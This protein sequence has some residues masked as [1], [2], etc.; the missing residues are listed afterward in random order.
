MPAAVSHVRG[1][2]QAPSD[3]DLEVALVQAKRS[4]EALEKEGREEDGRK[5]VE[6]AAATVN[7]R[8]TQLQ[9]EGQLARAE[10]L[11]AAARNV[12]EEKLGPNHPE[13][14]RSL[15]NL[16][17]AYRDAVNTYSSSYGKV[18]GAPYRVDGS[19]Y[20]VHPEPPAPTDNAPQPGALASF[21][22]KSEDAE[23]DEKAKEAAQSLYMR[24]DRQSPR[25]WKAQVVPVLTLALKKASTSQEREELARTLGHL[26]PVARESVPVLT[27]CLQK[28]REPRERQAILVALGDM[29]PAAEPAAPVLVDALRYEN[30]ETRRCAGEA[31]VRMGPAARHAVPA[32]NQRAEAKDAVAQEVLRR[33]QG[34]E[35]R[36]GVADKCDCFSLQALRLAHR[37]IHTLA[38][39]TGVEVLVE[40]VPTLTADKMADERARDLGV[41]GVYLLVAHDT[42]AVQ[43]SVSEP[44]RKQGLTADRVRAAVEPRLRQK[45]F[46]SAL[47]EGVQVVARFEETLR[48]KKAP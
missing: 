45:D 7:R 15:Q 36:I 12:C 33:I 21:Q 31:I 8:A 13:T 43:V 16:A 10:P 27:E 24:L 47:R 20:G 41:Q 17:F 48:D 28:A 46:D 42:P 25:E 11:L 2:S 5:L 30:P 32:L 29:G 38:A 19:I 22:N 4:A 34:H 9:K 35:G 3:H 14:Q 37:Q 23:K 18:A 1:Q 26:G 39:T 40:T 6:H 44:L